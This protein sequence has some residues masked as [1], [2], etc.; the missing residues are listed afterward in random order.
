VVF[1]GAI[2]DPALEEAGPGEDPPP[3]CQ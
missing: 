3:P 2:G 1:I